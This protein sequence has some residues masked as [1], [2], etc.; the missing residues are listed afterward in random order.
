MK[1]QVWRKYHCCKRLDIQKF[2]SPLWRCVAKKIAII[3]D[4]L[5]LD[6]F[7]EHYYCGNVSSEWI[8]LVY[9]NILFLELSLW[10]SI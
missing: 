9:D 7:R 8:D 3:K 4:R 5:L 1:D 10:S 2:V 6:M